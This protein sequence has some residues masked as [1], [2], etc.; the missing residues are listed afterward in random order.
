MGLTRLQVHPYEAQTF[1]FGLRRDAI[2]IVL[3][4]VSKIINESS[5]DS[6]Q[7]RVFDNIWGGNFPSPETLNL[8]TTIFITYLIILFIIR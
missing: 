6:G 7:Q 4:I 5:L 2:F 3:L 1:L 8:Y